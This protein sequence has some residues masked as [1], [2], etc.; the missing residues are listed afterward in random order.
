MESPIN[1]YVDRIFYINMDKDIDRNKNMLEQFAKH[2]ITNY[3]RFSGICVSLEE[4]NKYNLFGPFPHTES[5]CKKNNIDD[6]DIC[7]QKNNGMIDD[8]QMKGHAK[9]INDANCNI[10]TK[11]KIG[12]VGCL[13]SHKKIIEI[14]KERQ[15][16]KILILEDDV[17]FDEKFNE[18]FSNRIRDIEG[19]NWNILYLGLGQYKHIITNKFV[20]DSKSLIKI[21]GGGTG[22]FGYIINSNIYN[23]ILINIDYCKIEI[24][25]LYNNL[26]MKN[27]TQSY[28]FPENLIKVN[29]KDYGSSNIRYSFLE[30]N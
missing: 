25:L 5:F 13:L 16:G 12:S 23:Y 4:A 8:E 22:A 15:Y 30:R 24:D 26:N 17:I 19:Y 27:I 21:N 10:C 18:L 29:F 1:K 9:C 3:E 14:A 11:Y 2:G 20:N 28:K 6:C 7:H